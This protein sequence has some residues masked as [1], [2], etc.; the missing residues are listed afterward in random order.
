MLHAFNAL[1]SALQSIKKQYNNLSLKTLLQN[2]K[3]IAI[4]T[5]CSARISK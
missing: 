3:V 2:I 5:H 4:L 1:K